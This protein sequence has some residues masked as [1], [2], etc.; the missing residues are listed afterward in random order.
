VPNAPGAA[1]RP[2]RRA[3]T[4]L[5]GPR[6]PRR[7]GHLVIGTPDLAST[8]SLLVDGLGFKVSDSLDGVIA[9]LRCSTDHHNVGVVES[10]VPQLQHYSWECDDVDH[11]G[12]T[13]TAL[14]RVDPERQVWGMG[15]HFAGSNFY[16][17]LRD[18]SGS[19]IELY[20]DLEPLRAQIATGLTN[21]TQASTAIGTR[22]KEGV[23]QIKALRARIQNIVFGMPDLSRVQPRKD[24]RLETLVHNINT[25]SKS[26]DTATAKASETISGV[27]TLE[28][29]REGGLIK[30]N[31]DILTELQAPLKLDNPPPQAL[32]TFP[33][34][35]RMLASIGA[36]DA[37]MVRA[38]DAARASLAMLDIGLGDLDLFVQELRRTTLDS[39]GDLVL[40]DYKRLEPAMTKAVDSLNKAAVG[41]T[42][43][44]QLFNMARARQLETRIDMLGLQESPDRYATFQ[45]ALDVR[46]HTKGV[47]YADLA[48]Q[49]QRLQ[50][51]GLQ[52]CVGGS[53]AVFPVSAAIN[54]DP[55]PHRRQLIAHVRRIHRLLDVAKVI[56]P[57][58][59]IVSGNG[60]VLPQTTGASAQLLGKL[61]QLFP[62][63]IA[64][65]FPAALSLRR[66]GLSPAG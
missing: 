36:A 3:P 4:V 62:V 28:R 10:P 15:R 5:E 45:H 20:S 56:G 35:P 40:S 12:H 21:E 14:Y 17:Y 19:F 47:E 37:D 16:W 49:G 23:D 46:F 59:V 11:V 66:S 44:S 26:L 53:A 30:E 58:C 9:F 63:G 18:P 22:R 64:A 38:V 13:A 39:S 60:A 54:S 51:L 50:H 7:L 1:V 41:S 8:V 61:P 48:R 31:A 52:L 65:A 27:G 29:N 33:S 2:D 57:I 55:F 25:M 43:A 42:Q 32:A 34:Y 6:P 24:S